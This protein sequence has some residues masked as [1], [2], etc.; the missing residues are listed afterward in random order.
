LKAFLVFLDESGMLM[1]PNVRRSWAPRGQTPILRQRTRHYQKVS[2]ISVLCVSPE[3]DRVQLFFRLHSDTNINTAMV[4]EFLRYLSRELK[5]PVVMIWDRLQTH[6]SKEMSLFLAEATNIHT[7]FL[8]P[9]APELNPVENVWGYLKNNPLANFAA[10][11][12]DALT[13]FTRHNGRSIQNRPSLLRSFIRHSP[14]F[15][16][17]R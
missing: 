1:A 13:D 11:E 3:R 5:N 2:M 7:E 16:R 17:L 9:Y 4:I 14:L 8:P 6:R 15:L 10:Y 12:I